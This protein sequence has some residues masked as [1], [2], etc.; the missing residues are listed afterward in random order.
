MDRVTDPPNRQYTAFTAQ[1]ATYY[2][3]RQPA[4]VYPQWFVARITY[5]D[6]ATPQHATGAGYVLFTQ[7]AKNAPWKNVLEPYMLTGTGPGPSIQTTAHP[8]AIPPPAP[9][10]PPLT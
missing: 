10:Q 3:P 7:A 5:A 9:P 1:T 6:L 8:Y 4:G 2:I